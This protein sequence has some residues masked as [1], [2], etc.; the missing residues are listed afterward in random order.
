MSSIVSANKNTKRLAKSA[1]PTSSSIS[2]SLSNLSLEQT[3]LQASRTLSPDLE[4]QNKIVDRYE[5]KNVPQLEIKTDSKV[6]NN[7]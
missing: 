3:N 4:Y 2:S 1:S 7:I 5:M 6:K